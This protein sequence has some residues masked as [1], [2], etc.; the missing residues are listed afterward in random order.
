[1]K[2]KN[3]QYD[4]KLKSNELNQMHIILLKKK[5]KKLIPLD[6]SLFDQSSNFFHLICILNNSRHILQFLN[7]LI[8]LN[9]IQIFIMIH[10]ILPLIYSVQENKETI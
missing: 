7:F 2:L 9:V 8:E 3:N 1:M 6:I 5:K 4:Y 10:I